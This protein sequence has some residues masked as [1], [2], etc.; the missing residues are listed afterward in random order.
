LIQCLNEIVDLPDREREDVATAFPEIL[1]NAIERGGHREA[2]GLR[3]GAMVFWLPRSWLTNFI[4]TKKVTMLLIKYLND[5][6]LVPSDTSP[7][8]F[9]AT[10]SCTL[11][12]A[13]Q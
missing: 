2:Q 10:N 13:I 1:L 6:S 9:A 11:I 7:Y 4:T 5:V 8:R 3:P 12:L